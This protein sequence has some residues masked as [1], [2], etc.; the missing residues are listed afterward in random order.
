MWVIVQASGQDGQVLF[1]E[2]RTRPISSHLDQTSL[3]NKGFM[4]W[5]K[6]PKNDL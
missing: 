2:K 4:I 6:A 5:D 1:L 3:V